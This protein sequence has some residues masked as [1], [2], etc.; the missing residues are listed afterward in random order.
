M[1]K[2]FGQEEKKIWSLGHPSRAGCGLT[3]PQSDTVLKLFDFFDFFL[4]ILRKL[5]D[6]RG[7]WG[8][9]VYNTPIF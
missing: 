5:E 9:W 4:G 3:F 6:E 2:K 8:E 7:I 1:C